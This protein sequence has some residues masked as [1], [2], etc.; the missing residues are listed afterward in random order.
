M[1]HIV[2]ATRTT[3]DRSSTSTGI[4]RIDPRSRIAASALFA[5]VI[6]S[7]SDFY[8][9]GFGLAL[10]VGAMMVVRLPL[11]STLRKV[12]T[13]DTFIILMLVMLPFT[14]SGEALFTMG[15]LT[16]S[17]QGML[18]AV[19]IGLKANAIVMMLLALVGTLEATVLGHA[20]HRWRVP[21]SLV[22]LLLF[23]VRYIEVLQQELGRL[24]IAMRARC[25]LA[26][27]NLHT[28]RSIGYLLGM[29]LVRSLERS[30]RIMDAMKCR[31]F[32][33]R[34]YLLTSFDFGKQDQ[35]FAGVCG[36]CVIVLAFLEYRHWLASLI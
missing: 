6:V 15:P 8:A 36:L 19:A 30:E 25:F 7:L 12:A 17:V 33:G 23:A 14:T 28:Y 10:A 26:G 22:H 2:K 11:A 29:M 5:V 9:L 32:Q 16:A 21:E 31:G 20:L 35:A 1:G 18:Q 34:F 24:R 27:N 4:D 13:M 3:L